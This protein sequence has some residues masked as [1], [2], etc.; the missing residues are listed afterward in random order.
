MDE[1]PEFSNNR[2]IIQNATAFMEELLGLL[3]DVSVVGYEDRDTFRQFFSRERY[4]YGNTWTYLTQAMNSVGE[5][6]LGY[7]YFDGSVLIPIVAYPDFESPNDLNIYF[8]RPMGENC[9]DRIVEVRDSIR[10][11]GITNPI[12][13]KKIFPEQEKYLLGKGFKEIHA[14]PWH[15]TAIAEDDTFPEIIIDKGK[16]LATNKEGQLTHKKI[17]KLYNTIQN[18]YQGRIKFVEADDF[19]TQAWRIT[20]EFFKETVPKL[21]IPNLS[22]PRDYY[23]MIHGPI[24]EGI[25]KRIVMLGKQPVGFFITEEDY[26]R[27]YTNL[28]ASIALRQKATRL[29]DAT[30][31]HLLENI[32]TTFLDLGGSETQMLD[33]FKRKFLPSREIGLKW[34][35]DY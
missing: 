18:Q 10:E 35:V 7:K 16:A 17:R 13:V 15:K 30:I 1:I 26:S 27:T 22:L 20:A 12:Y 19:A 25:T 32:R 5:F 21:N 34:V 33:D 31:L 6:G 4:T 2:E 14:R 3:P 29:N 11:S 28:Y 23:N 8:I 9:L 24:E